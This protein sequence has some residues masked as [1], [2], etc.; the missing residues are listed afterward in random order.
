MAEGGVTAWGR[1]AVPWMPELR[2]GNVP[3]AFAAWEAGRDSLT[4]YTLGVAAGRG[5]TLPGASDR[6]RALAAGWIESTE[7]PAG[8][9]GV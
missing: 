6:L 2:A 4:A 8:Q 1:S 3:G 9:E 5:L 7:P